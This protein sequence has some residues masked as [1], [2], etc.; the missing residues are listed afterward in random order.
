M[1]T[2]AG[3]ETYICLKWGRPPVRDI[4]NFWTWENY[5]RQ[6]TA[7][8]KRLPVEFLV[9]YGYLSGP[10]SSLFQP[11]ETDCLVRDLTKWLL[12]KT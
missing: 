4:G 2:D 12:E 1:Q 5:R 7:Y 3:T 8:M 10:N 11:A 9:E 6:M